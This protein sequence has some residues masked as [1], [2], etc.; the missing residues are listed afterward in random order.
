VTSDYAD[1]A[2]WQATGR[3]TN[4]ISIDP[5]FVDLL[6]LH[7][8]SAMLNGAALPVASVVL[9]IDGD[10][11][12]AV[13][14]DIGADEFTTIC[15]TCWLGGIVAYVDSA[16]VGADDGTTW[17]DAFTELQDA[18]LSAKSFPQIEQIWI[19]NGTYLPTAGNQRNASFVLE[20]TM[21]V[22]GGFAG[23]ELNLVDR[24]PAMNSVILSGDIGVE[25][26]STDNSYKV[27]VITSGCTSCILDGLTLSHGN[28]DGLI[29]V[30]DKGAGV[31]SVGV[32]ALRD[33]IIEFNTSIES[34]AAVLSDGVQSQITLD[35][36]ILRF[37]NSLSGEDIYNANGAVLKILGTLQIDDD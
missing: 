30:N 17:T 32:A 8:L 2:S 15:D 4:S 7:A 37:N 33:L 23:G 19:A 13:T 22:Y 34:G 18:L 9:D 6:D 3:D 26:D 36:C 28:A 25:G 12:D 21:E 31:S 10:I 11:R 1:L 14:P 35:G 5:Q 27:V 29:N 20:D 24:I 16:A